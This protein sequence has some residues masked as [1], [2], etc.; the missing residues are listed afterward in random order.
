V[1]SFSL[2][3]ISKTAAIF[4]R[5]KL[6]WMN[7]VYLRQLSPNEFVR[8]ATPFLDR[9]LPITVR[10]PLDSDYAR[11]VM[12]LI[13]ERAKT[14]AEVPCL[15]DFF[16]LDE[17]QYET[18]SLLSKGLSGESAIEAIERP[19]KR[20][21]SVEVWDAKSIEDILRP[22]AA[23]LDLSTGRFFGLLRVAIT[24]RSAAPPL[25]QTMAV[26]GK[27]KCFE[28]LTTALHKLSALAQS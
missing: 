27:E 10:R 18:S 13:Q 21:G 28:R 16:F 20:L 22:L 9:D 26:L 11:R 7:G 12:P 23:E 3:R 15:A 24:G 17:L 14:L 8:R 6:E 19:L 5:Q 4:D 25:F 2:E 1:K